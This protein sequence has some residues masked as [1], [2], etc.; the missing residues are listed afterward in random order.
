MH[1][2]VLADGGDLD[3]L[4]ARPHG[5]HA[6]AQAPYLARTEGEVGAFLVRPGL[7]FEIEVFAQHDGSPVGSG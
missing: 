1:A 5:H 4:A 6:R 7:G 3:L 2:R